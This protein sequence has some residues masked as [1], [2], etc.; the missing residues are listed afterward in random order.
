MDLDRR[1]QKALMSIPGGQHLEPQDFHEHI[2]R[3]SNGTGNP[4]ALHMVRAQRARNIRSRET[5]GAT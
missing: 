5:S 1:V 4:F 3:A 2:A